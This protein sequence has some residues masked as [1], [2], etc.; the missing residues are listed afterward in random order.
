V[1][2]SRGFSNAAIH[3]LLQCLA[4]RRWVLERPRL[5]APRSGWSDGRR[6]FG[7]VGDA[8]VAA[9]R[10]AGVQMPLRAIHAAVRHRLDVDISI[11]WVADYLR[12]RSNGSNPM[13]VRP[14]SGH[15]ALRAVGERR[16]PNRPAIRLGDAGFSLRR[17]ASE[18]D[19]PRCRARRS[20]ASGVSDIAVLGAGE[21]D[22]RA[23]PQRL[24]SLSGGC[25]THEQ[26]A[27]PPACTGGAG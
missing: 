27:S 6:G 23:D 15:Y 8:V 19:T 3:D 17:W 16:G 4:D 25:L 22:R 21:S 20:R 12:G 1:V 7:E 5:T 13:F 18:V 10:D 9:L 24:S 14:C 2:L 11:N 26:T